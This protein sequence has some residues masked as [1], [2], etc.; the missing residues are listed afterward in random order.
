M[1]SQSHSKLSAISFLQSFVVQSLKVA[2][3]L[4]CSQCGRKSSYIEHLGLGASICFEKACR[5]HKGIGDG[6][7]TADQYAD[8]IVSIKN[9]I[10]GNFSRASSQAGVVRVVN[11]RCPFGD[12]VKEAPELCRMT[13]SVFGGIAARNMGYAKVELKKRIATG[14]DM[15]EVLIYLDPEKAKGKE[16][17]EYH[18]AGDLIVSTSLSS[19]VTM[20]VQEKFRQF[21]CAVPDGSP[22]RAGRPSIVAE[23]AAMRRALEA[24]ERVAPTTA[25]VLILGETGVGKEVIARAIHALSGR[26]NRELVAVNCGAIPES[27]I[28]SQLFGHEKG[29][30]TGAYQVHHGFFE[31][32]ERGTLFLDEINSLPLSAQTRLLRVLQDGTYER[33]GGKHTLRADVRVVAASNRSIEEMVAAGQFRR[34]LFYRLNVVPIYIPPL[35]E[36][37]EDISALTHHML[38]QL[39]EKYGTAAKTLSERAWI[40]IMTYDW[41]GNVRELENVLER[42]FLFAEGAVIEEILFDSQACALR[43]EPERFGLRMIKRQAAMQIEDKVIREALARYGGNVTAVAR[44]MGITPRA[45]HFKLKAYGI[46]AKLYRNRKGALAK[47]GCERE[48]MLPLR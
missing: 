30:F 43:T 12:A 40:Q 5:E 19:E 32:A 10:G 26:R 34:D 36:R 46:D 15:C 37:K 18:R 8:V 33:V 25:T 35:R 2:N 4:G 9:Q 38:S 1:T 39:S 24:V 42:S 14:A 41:P 47:G 29:A 16:G 48:A 44:E 31:R 28:E 22:G 11:T 21:W 7:L 23:S 27:L 45:V 6:P 17:D 20:R 13:S 3:Q